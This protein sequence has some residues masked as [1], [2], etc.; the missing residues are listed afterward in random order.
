MKNNI[1]DK[2]ILFVCFNVYNYNIEIKNKL[3]ELGGRVDMFEQVKYSLLYTV[4]L[5][6]RLGKKYKQYLANRI[7]AVASKKKYDFVFVLEI[8]QTESFYKRLREVQSEARFILYYWDSIKVFDYRPFL[9]YFDQ[10]YSFDIDDVKDNKDISY[11][12]LFF[13]DT[14]ASLREKT[15]NEFKYDFL[16]VATFSM[17]KYTNMNSFIKDY[18]VEPSRLL[19]YYRT[20]LGKYFELLFKK[21]DMKWIGVKKKTQEE[22]VALYAQSKCIIDFD[23]KQQ[24]GLSMRTIESLGAGKKLITSNSRLKNEPIYDPNNIFII[25]VDDRR[26]LKNFIDKGFVYSEQIENYSIKN[27]CLRLFSE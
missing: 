26:M 4:L 14:Y 24:S 2:D 15:I 17:E 3:I 13:T 16:Q 20:T 22:I 8:H 10:A 6:L 5:R 23:K 19:V 27:F 12:P 18:S 25:G 21:F 1:K 9:K 7:I 11:L